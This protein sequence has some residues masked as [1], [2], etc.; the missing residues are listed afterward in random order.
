[1]IIIDRFEGETAVCDVDGDELAIARSV[2]PEDVSEGDVITP[3]EDGRYL[4]DEEATHKRRAALRS[5]LFSLT[6]KSRITEK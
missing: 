3:V 5:R 6:H 2:L 4:V 1:M